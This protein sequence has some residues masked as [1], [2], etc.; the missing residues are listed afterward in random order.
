MAE[1]GFS[2]VTKVYPD[3]TTAVRD[4]TLQIDDGQLVVLVGPSGCGKTTVLR[5]V[6]GLEDV[7]GGEI[8]VDGRVVNDVDPSER[9]VA[10]VFQTYALYP[11]MTVGQNIGFPLK[12]AKLPRDEQ[13]R[14]VRDV[15][16]LLGL[17]GEL[18]RRP[19]QLSGGQRQRVAMGRAI[20]RQPQVFLMDEPLSNLDASLRFQ[21]RAEIANLQQRVGV[22][23][24]YVTHDQVEAMTI[25]NR[26]AVMRRG[27]LLQFGDPQEIYDR[28]QDLFVARFVGSPPMNLIEGELSHDGGYAVS[29]AGREIPLDAAETADRGVLDPYVGRS[30]VIGFRPERLEDAA[31]ASDVPADRRISGTVTLRE[32]LGSDILVHFEVEGSRPLSGRVRAAAVEAAVDPVELE[33]AADEPGLSFIGRFDPRSRARQRE[34]V[35]AAIR[36]GAMQLFDPETGAAIG[37]L[38]RAPTVQP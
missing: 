7:S 16:R 24:I 36:P 23:T 35:Q 3:G 34:R 19:R 14:R 5:M 17:D 13:E 15:A 12:I 6:A 33:P 29:I 22:T 37:R 10:M 1:V 8:R 32:T 38:V 20:V 2:H 18:N 25:G 30:V 4:L 11:H 31:V 26:V 27:E 28:P 9:D 21:M